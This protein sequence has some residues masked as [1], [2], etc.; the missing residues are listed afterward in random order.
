MAVNRDRAEEKRLLE[1]LFDTV[2][3]D[4]PAGI[5]VTEDPNDPDA[6]VAASA[7]SP[8]AAEPKPS[9]PTTHEEGDMPLSDLRSRL[10][11]ADDA[12][13]SAVLA[14]V[15]DLKTRADKPEPNPAEVAAA[16]AERDGLRKE[17]DL[18]AGQVETLS[19]EVAAAKAKE[20]ATVKASVLDAA[21]AAGK[22]P[23][24]ERERW[25]TDY[26]E[27]P[28]AVTRVLASIAPGTAVPVTP[29][30]TSGT[31][32]VAASAADDALYESVYGK[33]D[34]R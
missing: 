20:A 28:A 22:F 6:D 13:E 2:S 17:V 14:A 18:L 5:A 7:Q 23:P 24:A 33:D 4:K 30:G 9:D 10:G 21:Q 8:S 3:F 29:A 34:A 19:G 27:A 1:G 26:D 16:A 25:D 11:L 31:N 15:D 12:D 32:E